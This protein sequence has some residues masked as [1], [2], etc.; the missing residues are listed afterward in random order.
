M[1]ENALCISA[2]LSASVQGP[3]PSTQSYLVI[4]AI[5]DAAK[6]TGAQ[7]RMSVLVHD[8]TCCVVD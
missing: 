8:V 2:L 6:K 1:S 5:V 7:V 4:D 3:P